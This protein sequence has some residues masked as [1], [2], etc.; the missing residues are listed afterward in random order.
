MLT[1]AE[2]RAYLE[3]SAQVLRDAAGRRAGRPGDDQ[4]PGRAGLQLRHA[5]RRRLRHRHQ[6]A[7]RAR[8][9]PAC[10]YPD[11]TPVA[12]AEQFVVA[13]NNY[14]R[15]PAAATSPASS[16][17]QVLQRPA[18]D[19]PAADRLGTGEGLDRPG[20]LLRPELAAGARERAGLR[21]TPYSG[22]MQ[23]RI[24]GTDRCPGR[25]GRARRLAARRRLGRGRRGPTPWP[26]LH[27]ARRGRA[28]PSSTPPTCTATAAANASSAG[29]LRDYA[30]HGLTVA[31]KM[32][33]RVA[34]GRRRLHP[35]QLPRLE[36]PVPGQPRRGHPRPRP[37]ALPAVGGLRRRRGLRRLDTM[38]AEKRIAAYGV[39]V[40]TCA[41]ALDRDRPAGRRHRADHPQHAS[42]SSRWTRCC[43]PPRRSRGRDHRPGAAR[44]R[45]A[46]RP[47]RR[48]H[49]L[50]RRRPPHLQPPRRGVR[51]G[52]DL[53]RRRLRHRPGRGAP[54]RAAGRP[55][56]AR[57]PS[58]RCGGSS[59]SPAVSRGHPRRPQ[60][61][62][63]PAATPPRPPCRR[64]RQ[65]AH[66][67]S[68]RST[69]S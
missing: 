53:L 45:P 14:R 39:S 69:T 61:R 19:P 37:A 31:T 38:V 3:Y 52:R 23:E 54:A 28:S 41:E 59:T 64:C 58:S 60:R 62:P 47:L 63:G 46:V 55:R 65:T 4:R 68:A 15:S 9:S 40:E 51:R 49:H 6:Q 8:A 27:A 35:G 5:L 50:R 25:R 44:Q 67:R 56:G 29:S 34:A 21:V 2:V 20:R 1:G 26:T 33:R 30:G 18:G 12:D 13:V 48:A 17:P 42:G 66:A 24:L 57:W 11:G 10:S 22:R 32:G 16:R 36:R 43:R 7:G